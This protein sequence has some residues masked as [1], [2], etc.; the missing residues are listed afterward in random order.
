M[1]KLNKYLSL[2]LTLLIV[3]IWIIGCSPSPATEAPT[4]TLT[5]TDRPPTVTAIPSS[6]NTPAPSNTPEP[7]NT[8]SPYPTTPIE[9]RG[10]R[11][12]I[13]FNNIAYD[14]SLTTSWG[15]A[16]FIEYDGHVLLFDTGGSGSILLENMEQLGLD[17]QLIEVVVLSHIHGDHTDGLIDLLYT[18]IKPIVYLPKAFPQP[19]KYTVQVH[20][21]VVEVREPIEILPGIYSTGELGAIVEQ[22]LILETSSGGRTDDT[23]SSEHTGR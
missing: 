19:F 6:T 10:A 16:A 12:T 7:T 21:E 3:V 23:Q 22:A 15:F 4:V 2:I 17:P 9:E 5:S 11:I 8:P 20:T 13:V 14:T 1:D 18:G